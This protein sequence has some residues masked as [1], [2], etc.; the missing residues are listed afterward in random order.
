MTRA[1]KLAAL[2]KLE[3]LVRDMRRLQAAYFRG[4]DDD[5]LK[6]AKAAERAVDIHL[7]EVKAS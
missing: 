6:Q 2:E 5:V 1:D 7:H 3:Q 4:R